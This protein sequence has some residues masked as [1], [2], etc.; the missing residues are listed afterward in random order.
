LLIEDRR[1]RDAAVGGFPKTAERGRDVPHARV[2]GIDLDVLN[3][4]G[5]KRRAEASQLQAFERLRIKAV[6]VLS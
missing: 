1:E 6:T 2:F 5:G 4:A 3:S